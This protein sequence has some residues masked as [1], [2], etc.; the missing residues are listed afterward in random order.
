MITFP[1]LSNV[2]HRTMI[3]PVSPL[4]TAVLRGV[5]PF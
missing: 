5:R 2:R 1:L 4:N 3:T